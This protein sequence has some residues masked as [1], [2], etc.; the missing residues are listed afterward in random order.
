MSASAETPA[1]YSVWGECAKVAIQVVRDSKPL[2]PPL[3][4]CTNCGETVTNLADMDTVS[5]L[6]TLAIEHRCTPRGLE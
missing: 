6:I 5:S 4:V 3:I 2:D 1:F